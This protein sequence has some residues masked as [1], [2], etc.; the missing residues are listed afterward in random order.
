MTTL[1]YPAR[2][3]LFTGDIWP[4][5]RVS[6]SRLPDK[7]TCV[8]AGEELMALYLAEAV[9]FAQGLDLWRTDP[10]RG[11]LALRLTQAGRA[12]AETLDLCELA[13]AEESWHLRRQD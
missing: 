7:D 13:G 1:S 3:L 6:V 5:G 2:L 10:E 8:A 9:P 11:P 4:D 12:A